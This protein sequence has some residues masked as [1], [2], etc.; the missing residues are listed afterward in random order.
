[1]TYILKTIIK[2][3]NFYLLII[4]QIIVFLSKKNLKLIIFM[5][6]TIKNRV[7]FYRLEIALTWIKNI[8]K[9]LIKIYRSIFSTLIVVM[10]IFNK[11]VYLNQ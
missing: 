2:I 9:I 10:M 3:H 5:K 11:K 4:N 1:M 8:N 7:N 6:I